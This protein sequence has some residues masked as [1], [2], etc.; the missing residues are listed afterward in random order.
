MDFAHPFLNVIGQIE[1][2]PLESGRQAY[3]S[4]GRS[5]PDLA[6]SIGEIRRHHLNI[7]IFLGAEFGNDYFMHVMG[8]ELPED[9][10]GF[11]FNTGT[12]TAG[13]SDA[14]AVA[15]DFFAERQR[16]GHH[17]HMLC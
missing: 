8:A 13:E 4:W 12:F 1:R 7:A 6:L 5:Q 14:Y 2:F 9:A 11:D 10:S 17:L 16:Y 15:E 3:V